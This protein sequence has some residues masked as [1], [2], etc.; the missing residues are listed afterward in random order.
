MSGSSPWQEVP[1]LERPPDAAAHGEAWHE[2]DEYGLAVLAL[3]CL[4][5]DRAAS[6]PAG[7]PPLARVTREQ[8]G[9]QDTWTRPRTPQE[10]ADVDD[11]LDHLLADAGVPARPRGRRWYLRLPPG[12]GLEESVREWWWEINQRLEG[13]DQTPADELGVLEEILARE[14]LRSPRSG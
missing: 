11:D 4:R 13:T 5:R 12:Q 1:F 8:S 2:V 14:G 3:W 6:S 10:Q 9:T 7:D